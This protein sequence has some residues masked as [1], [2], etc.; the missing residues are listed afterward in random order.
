MYETAHQVKKVAPLI[1][2]KKVGLG[3]LLLNFLIN[4]TNGIQTVNNINKWNQVQEELAYDGN[5]STVL[6]TVFFGLRRKT[7]NIGS[8]YAYPYAGPNRL[9]KHCAGQGTVYTTPDVCGN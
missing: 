5:S 4:H 7:W 8:Y 6:V 3:S 9:Y 1:A 2:S